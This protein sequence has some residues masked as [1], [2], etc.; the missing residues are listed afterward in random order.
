[1]EVGCDKNEGRHSDV[2]RTDTLDLC[3]FCIFLFYVLYVCIII[4]HFDGCIFWLYFLH[5]FAFAC[6]KSDGRQ[7]DVG[8]ESVTHWTRGITPCC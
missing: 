8:S 5:F 2:R 7:C 4:L 1:M 3:V 6:D